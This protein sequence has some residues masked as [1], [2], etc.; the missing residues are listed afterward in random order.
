M[1]FSNGCGKAV[2]A[3]LIVCFSALPACVQ[4]LGATRYLV[5]NNDDDRTITEVEAAP[6][7]TQNYAALDTG[8][9]LIG[10]RSGQ[11]TVALPALGCRWDL[12][13]VYRDNSLLTVTGWNACRQ[14][15]VH[16]GA[17]RQAALRQRQPI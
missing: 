14:A 3:L 11:A 8:C 15:I 16:F 2:L 12:R 17:A 10:G 5:V 6:A 1:D 13:V 7:G 4:A 9:P